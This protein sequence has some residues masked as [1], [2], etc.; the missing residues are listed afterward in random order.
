MQKFITATLFLLFFATFATAQTV[1]K[2]IFVEYTYVVPADNEMMKMLYGNNHIRVYA[3]AGYWSIANDVELPAEQ[4]AAMGTDGL[5]TKVIGNSASGEHFMC[6]TFGDKKI[7]ALAEADDVAQ[8]FAQFDLLNDTSYVVASK[9]SD[10]KA[11]AAQSCRA[12]KLTP[13]DVEMSGATIYLSTDITLAPDFK[14]C[15]VAVYKD[16]KFEGVLLG[17]DQESGFNTQLRAKVVEIDAVRNIADELG[18]YR[19]VTKEEVNTIIGAW[20]SELGKKK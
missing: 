14:K 10:E 18:K 13:K 4:V 11:I 19:T 3:D 7:K 12:V 8:V 5:K 2:S 17:N 1:A 9:T 20:M 6:F 15:P 16:G